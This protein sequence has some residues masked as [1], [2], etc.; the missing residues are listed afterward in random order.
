MMSKVLEKIAVCTVFALLL[1]A[2]PIP[3][4][5]LAA[6]AAAATAPEAAD[7]HI[8][9]MWSLALV[10]SVIALIFAYIFFKNMMA[11]DEGN[12]RMIEIAGHVRE[13][14]NAYLTQRYKVVAGFFL[15]IV[16]LL[17]IA[18]FVLNVQSKFAPFAFLTGGFFSELAG[19]FGM[20]TATWPSS[21]TSAGAQKSLNQGLQVAFRSVSTTTCHHRHA[22]VGRPWPTLDNRRWT[23]MAVYRG[24]CSPFP[25]GTHLTRIS[26]MSRPEI[27]QS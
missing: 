10:S 25:E 2:V 18:A 13:G 4:M 6:D 20:K 5:L 3:N 11:A 7:P 15:V 12:A 21:R 27:F 23:T 16:I 22:A 1:L 24:T 14:A 26:F 9:M 19:W 8:K 17:G